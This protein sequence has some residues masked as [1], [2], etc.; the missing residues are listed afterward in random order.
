MKQILQ[1]LLSDDSKEESVPDD[2]TH[3]P[4]KKL[5]ER[6]AHE[7]SPWMILQIMSEFIKGFDFLKHYKK[8][9]R[10]SVV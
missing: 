4:Q 6:K 1:S 10:K 3:V 2:R 9:D 7:V 5:F 8:A